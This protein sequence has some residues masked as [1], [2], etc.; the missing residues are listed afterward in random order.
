MEDL[1]QKTEIDSIRIA[2]EKDRK[3]RSER[4]F[5]NSLNKTSLMAFA[6]GAGIIYGGIKSGD[7]G[8]QG[9]GY[10]ILAGTTLLNAGVRLTKSLMGKPVF[11]YSSEDRN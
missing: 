6:T 4:S 1:E 7:A 11:R 2:Y 10:G 9:F 3:E 5:L 8:V